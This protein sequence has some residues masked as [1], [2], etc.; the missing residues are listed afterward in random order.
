MFPVSSTADSASAEDGA[1]LGGFGRA[2]LGRISRLG[3]EGSVAQSV[4][5]VGP[6][7]AVLADE[8]GD[9]FC[10]ESS[11]CIMVEGLG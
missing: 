9:T 10:D 6:K 7:G 1:A 4:G 8:L 2:L 3:L 5:T 11:L